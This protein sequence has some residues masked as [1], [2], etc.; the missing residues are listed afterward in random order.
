MA[1]LVTLVAAAARAQQTRAVSYDDALRAARRAAP[2]LMVAQARERVAR[3]DVGIAGVYPNP[4]IIGGTSSQTAKLSATLSVPLVILGQRGAAV[5]AA[6]ADEATVA[7][8]TRVAWN[9]IRQQ[10]ARAFIGLWL[11]EGVAQA[12]GDSAAIEATL[13]SSVVQ[14]VQVGS[15]PEID[16]LRV[17][18]E[19][20]RTD[21]DLQDA[22]AHVNAAGSALGRWMG[23]SDGSSLRATQPPVV[24]VAPLPLNALLARLAESAPL[25]REISDVRASEAR[26]FRERALVRP[27]MTLDFG[28]DAFDPSL[29]YP[30]QPN[31]RAQLA[32]EVPIFN[33]R[34]PFID[35]ER[36]SGDIARA[37]VQSERVQLAAELTAAYQL[38]EAASARQRTLVE[39][40][41][42][43][44]RQAAKAMEDAYALGRVPL[45]AVLDA[46]R[47]LVDTRLTALD[48]QASGASAWVDVEHALGSP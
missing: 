35:R 3:A 2:E 22:V 48:S 7:Y 44:A 15:S 25:Q 19:K 10:T 16:A 27:L 29:T 23:L 30:N 21:A 41:V 11:A 42:P 43:A 39:A 32:V 5:D 9:D 46:E 34:G 8:D 36:A 6:R 28:F 12:R 20:L 33:Q 14:R 47:S 13:E 26:V 24:P 31:Y 1:L 45:V 4:T 40:V 38:F 37:R 18:A 17:H